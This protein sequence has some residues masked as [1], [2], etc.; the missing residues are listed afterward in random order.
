[1]GATICKITP[2]FKP[3]RKIRFLDSEI[4]F[5]IVIVYYIHSINRKV[6]KLVF[7]L[8]Q[9]WQKTSKHN[10]LS[11]YMVYIRPHFEY[12]SPTWNALPGYLIDNLEKLQRRAMHI[13]LGYLY[14]KELTPDN[15]QALK[16]HKLIDRCNLVLR[17]LGY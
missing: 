11:V 15:Y 7:L 13:I 17:C 8:K 2:G 9:L 1:M 6:A 16:L 12:A 10:L 3:R 4:D 14:R 5:V